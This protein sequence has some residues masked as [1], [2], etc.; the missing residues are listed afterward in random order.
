MAILILLMAQTKLPV[1][2][3]AVD[4]ANQDGMQL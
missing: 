2:C 3:C 4:G 1:D